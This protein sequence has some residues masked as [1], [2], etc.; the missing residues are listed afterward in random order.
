MK[1]RKPLEIFRGLAML[2]VLWAAVLIAVRLQLVFPRSV[3]VW[4][5]ESPNPQ[6]ALVAFSALVSSGVL[7]LLRLGIEVPPIKPL[8]AS[9]TVRAYITG[10][11]FWVLGSIF[12]V[13]IGALVLVFPACQSPAFVI[14]RVEG[15]PETYRPNGTLVASPGEFLAITAEPFEENAILSCR[16]QY[17]GEAFET[18]GAN[19][20]CELN[21]KLSRQ[22]G[23]GL[24][25]LQASQDFCNQSS[26]FSLGIQI[27]S[28]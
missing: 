7:A 22:P 19:T 8:I 26:V 18:V 9:E 13:A 27:E 14:F 4:L 2:L 28:P 11:P 1:T 15:R 6:Q 20:G 5:S 25:T 17:V 3:V 21:L 24:L 16:W 23:N 12:A 10:I